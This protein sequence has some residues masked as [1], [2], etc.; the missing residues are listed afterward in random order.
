MAPEG[1]HARPN[2]NRR[3][4]MPAIPSFD[5]MEPHGSF[6]SIDAQGGSVTKEPLSP[7][8]PLAGRAARQ[9]SQ[10]NAFEEQGSNRRR[11]Q[12][13]AFDEQGVNRP[14]MSSQRV[15]AIL[16]NYEFF[17][18]MDESMMQKM[19]SIVHHVCYP[20]GSILFR[21]GDPPGN[22]YAI[23]SGEVGIFVKAEEDEDCI[24]SARNFAA[25]RKSLFGKPSTPN[26][27][28]AS[29]A[30]PPPSSIPSSPMASPVASRQ[31]QII[32]A[33]P[34]ARLSL[35]SDLPPPRKRALS[36][37]ALE[38]SEDVEK[39]FARKKTAEGFSTY[40]EGSAI[41]KKCAVFGVGKLFGELALMQSQPRSATVKCTKDTEVLVI[42]KHNF[43]VVLKDELAKSQA[44]K[45]KFLCNHVPGMRDLPPPRP[46]KADPSYFF[47]KTPFCRDHEFLT[48]GS[49]A[50]DTLYIV[51]RGSVEFRR[52]ESHGES[53]NDERAV[54]SHRHR[55]GMRSWTPSHRH[56][57]QD[58]DVEVAKDDCIRKMG[59]MLAG[60]VFGS[61][62][63][64]GPEP[65]TVVAGPECELFCVSAQ[66]ATKLPRTVQQAIQEHLARTVAWRLA[67]LQSDRCI[68]LREPVS[69]NEADKT[70]KLAQ[71]LPKTAKSYGL[72]LIKVGKIH[73][74]PVLLEA[75]P[76]IPVSR[77]PSRGEPMSL[78]T[79]QSLPSMSPQ[80][81]VMSV[82]SSRSSLRSPPRPKSQGVATD[83]P[84]KAWD[85]PK[86]A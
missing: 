31:L 76:S 52:Y 36:L 20:E 55:R 67:R 48:Q 86:T 1:N 37:S 12:S 8:M 78:S 17:Q 74:H 10:S 63:F 45:I 19:P 40:H 41:G 11:F 81:S 65:F 6:L 22:C 46:G 18:N 80:A 72:N 61:L 51:W 70:A 3:C 68:F 43:E 49:P 13:S 73:P 77:A 7:L 60:S 29:G 57:R 5:G 83:S 15:N 28:T 34:S 56:T 14:Q 62:P 75:D 27:P 25:S 38:L 44:A 85:N 16:K 4:T 53:P 79:S 84:A 23:L 21:Q 2:M 71:L 58:D 30:T 32:P 47:K 9:R 54:S 35:V 66:D 24:D 42:C 33:S 50:P 39:D 59:I 64:P 26:T 82:G 69:K